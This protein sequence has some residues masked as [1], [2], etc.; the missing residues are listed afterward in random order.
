MANIQKRGDNSYFFTI[1]LGKGADGKYNRATKTITVTEKMSPKRLKEYLDHEYLKFKQEAKSNTYITPKKMTLISF[2]E[3]WKEKYA[4]KELSETTITNQLSIL[5]IHILPSIG[6]W[7]I[8]NINQSLLVDLLHNL[9]RQDGSERPLAVASQQSVYT[10]LKSIFKYAKQLRVIKEDPMEGVNKP[11]NIKEMKKELNVYSLEEVEILL[12]F[13]QEEESHWRVFMI[14]TLVAGLRRG[15]ALGLEW[16]KVDFDKNVIDIS[17]TIVNTRNGPLIKSPKNKT[18]KRLISLPPSLVTELEEFYLENRDVRHK[19][20]DG[21]TESKNDW[22]FCNEDGT[23]FYPTSPTTWWRRFTERVGMRYIRLHDLRHT[24][25]TLLIAKGIHAKVISERSGHSGIRIT[26]DTYGHVL[27]SADEE[28][29]N[30]FEELFNSTF[31][32]PIK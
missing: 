2:V 3:D 10:T 26:M 6:H 11:K 29:G 16:S 4:F 5:K 25:V 28:A 23:H 32:K 18:S 21:W 30:T 12:S 19:M 31:K 8:S 22:V 15:E 1:S 7:Q 24:S 17:Q 9:K 20:G 27:R 14:L 13:L